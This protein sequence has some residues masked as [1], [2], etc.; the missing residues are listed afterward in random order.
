MDRS[1]WNQT[2][3]T[4]VLDSILGTPVKVRLLRA[5]S[6]RGG[7]VSGREA[8][9][10]AGVASRSAAV[11]ALD[12]LSQLGILQR[13]EL[14]G[15]HLYEVN[16]RHDLAP[17]LATL[18]RAEWERF[19][20]LGEAV[21]DALERAG[22]LGGVL[23]AVI[24]GSTARGD[25]RPGSDLDLLLVATTDRSAAAAEQALLAF[26]DELRD[27]FGARVSPL[28]LTRARFR[29][30][31]RAGDPLLGNVLA[32]GRTLFGTPVQELAA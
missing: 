14:S 10:L 2:T 5:L 27:R 4:N 13:R 26:A 11:E 7:P 19:G 24:F 8:A 9:R 31:L 28:A 6:A 1:A 15:T 12:A 3:M 32:D 20:A 25:A 16:R 30:R 23:S 29:S 21:R 22:A 17:A 18:F